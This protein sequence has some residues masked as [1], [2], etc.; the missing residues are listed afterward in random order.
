MASTTALMHA[1][2]GNSRGLAQIIAIGEGLKY[3]CL[4]NQQVRITWI[5]AHCD[6]DCIDGTSLHYD[7]SK[8]LC[9]NGSAMRIA[10]SNPNHGF[11]RV[12]PHS[13]ISQKFA[14]CLPDSE[15]KHRHL[16]ACVPL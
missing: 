14:H 2:G 4:C 12:K 16:L 5:D 8:V 9:D 10:G 11:A 1:T 7:P 13:R 6:D 3:N 15:A